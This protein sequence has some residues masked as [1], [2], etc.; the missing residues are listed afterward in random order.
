MEIIMEAIIILFLCLGGFV[1]W[2][3]LT[4]VICATMKARR[5]EL[6]MI[7]NISEE[8]KK[9]KKDIEELK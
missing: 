2:G 1:G 8:L 3:V 5:K 9:I 4:Y 6:I 7:E